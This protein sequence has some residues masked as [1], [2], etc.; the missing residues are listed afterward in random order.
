V[1]SHRLSSNDVATLRMPEHLN[2]IG[3]SQLN[4]NLVTFFV[5]KKE[6]RVDRHLS[7]LSKADAASVRETAILDIRHVGIPHTPN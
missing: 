2:A 5:F 1:A 3:P 4:A 6:G 7:K